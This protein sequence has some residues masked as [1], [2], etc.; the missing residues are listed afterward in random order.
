[1]TVEHPTSER[2]ATRRLPGWIALGLHVA[3]G[4]FPYGASGL[5]AP[6]PGLVVLG[7][8]WIALLVVVLRWRPANP[9]MT[10]LAPA[11]A[12]AIWFAVLSLG[13]AVFGW[14]A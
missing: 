1:M 7:I 8:I 11:G 6:L 5:V 14:T 2:S 9:W 4:V 12:V 3:V 13:E 10:L